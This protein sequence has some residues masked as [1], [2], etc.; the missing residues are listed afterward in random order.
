MRSSRRPE[1]R[2]VNWGGISLLLLRLLLVAFLWQRRK[3]LLGTPFPLS[4]LW[5]L[6]ITSSLLSFCLE[7]TEMWQGVTIPCDFPKLYPHF[8]N[9]LV[10]KFSLNYSNVTFGLLLKTHRLMVDKSVGKTKKIHLIHHKF[11]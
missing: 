7:V 5:A 10:S 3:L 4:L 9:S 2:N 11:T 6:S 1:G 8:V